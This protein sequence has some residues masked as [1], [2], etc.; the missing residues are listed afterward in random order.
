MQLVFE[1]EAAS[2]SPTIETY[3]SVI[4]L[5]C[6]LQQPK[7]AHDML[8]LVQKQS[9]RKLDPSVMVNVLHVCAT[10]QY[11]CDVVC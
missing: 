10:E 3:T 4:L 8:L 2:I 7:L 1:A 5:A 9:A 11:V 6:H